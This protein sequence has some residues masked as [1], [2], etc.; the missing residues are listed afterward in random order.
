M[1]LTARRPGGRVTGWSLVGF[2]VA[3]VVA[4]PLLALPASF[5][6]QG[7]A[8][9]QIGR[10]LLPDALRTSVVLGLGMATRKGRLTDRLLTGLALACVSIPVFW[11]GE[12]M[13]LVT[14]SRF[15]DSWLFA[16]V[17]PL[18]YKPLLEDP[19]GWFKTMLIPWLTL[20]TL[21]I[22][23]Y[24]R[25]LRG[26]LVEAYQE[27]FIRTARAKGLTERRVIFKHGLRSALTPIVTIFGLDFGLL[28]GGALLT[29][30][31]FNL[32][33]IGAYAYNAIQ[34]ND[35]PQ[36]LGVTLVAA[37]FVVFA[38]LVVDIVYAVVDPRVRYS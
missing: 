8:F 21:Y 23:L 13:N 31:V 10:T 3:V 17:P 15:H 11:L 12:V 29:E 4:G 36:I 27:D 20:A 25:V 30:T 9:D 33:G 18:G 7:E 26:S 35:L 32:P 34:Q 1:E 16:W 19:V 2:A 5:V 38:N 6:G 28:L 37:F 24:G 14:Q 22:G